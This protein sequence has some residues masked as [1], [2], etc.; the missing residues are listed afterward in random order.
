M[1][2]ALGRRSHFSQIIHVIGEP[3]EQMIPRGNQGDTKLVDGGA[4]DKAGRVGD[5]G[6]DKGQKEVKIKNQPSVL[7]AGPG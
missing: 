5:G 6:G 7:R 1:S 4:R 2:G 3:G